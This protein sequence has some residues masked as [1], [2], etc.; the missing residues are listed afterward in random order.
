MNMRLLSKL[1]DVTII[2]S[3]IIGNAIS[4]SLAR[5]GFKVSVYDT[6][7][8]PGYGTTSY[9][10]GICRM[11]YSLL[12]SVKFSWEGYHYWDDWENYI[13]YKDI[14]GYAKLNKCGALFLKSNN[15]NDFLTN[16]QR[17]M[18]QVGVP[19][20]PISFNE[21]DNY[22]SKMGMDIYNTYYPKN[23]DDPLFGDTNHK[24]YIDGSLYFPETGYI[25]DPL[26]AALNLYH[27]SKDLG[28]I[29]NFNTKIV[30]INVDNKHEISNIVTENNEVIESPIVINCGGPYSTEI[31]NLVYKNN[32]IENDSNIKCRPLRKEV[33]YTQLNKNKYNIDNNGI[34][35]ID[36]DIGIY[37]RPEIGNKLL[38]GS[39]E[40][41]CDELIWEDNLDS[42]DTNSS[43]L[44]FNQMCRAA[45][46]IPDLEIPNPK[47]QQFITSTYDV[48]DDWTPIYDKTNI[49]GYYTAIG[50]SGN[51]LKNAPVVGDMMSELILECENGL[52][53]DNNPLEYK[54][55]KTNNAINTNIFSRLRT[56]HNNNKN[57]FG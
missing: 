21:T 55:K 40:P 5:K 7:P 23:I 45:L 42:M 4:L 39:T 14:N 19:V 44:Y 2:G 51:Q 22:V 25:S 35:V 52:D 43:E 3:G 37:F 27:A 24:N 57:V 41:E 32:N 1:P 46:R 54:L 29:F 30:E 6:N 48:S 10:S 26:L 36:L 49:K 38:I 53:H 8:A 56:N 15:S 31:N 9:S 33:G 28:T 11:Y 16:S 17:L 13:Q 18:E 34:I 50:T 20:K 12:E 47:N